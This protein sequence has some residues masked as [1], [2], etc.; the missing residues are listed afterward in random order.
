MPGGSSFAD[1]LEAG[2]TSPSSFPSPHATTASESELS[3]TATE[4]LQDYMMTV[5][6]GAGLG[7]RGLLI[8]ILPSQA[9]LGG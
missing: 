4:L 9:G 5:G 3:T 1:T 7:G 6:L 8:L 2:D